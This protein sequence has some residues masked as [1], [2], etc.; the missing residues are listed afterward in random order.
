MNPDF[1]NQLCQ[2]HPRIFVQRHG[3]M[4]DTA[5]CWGFDCGD[6]WFTLLDVLCRE[7]QGQTDKHGAPQLEA[8]QVK[9]KFGALR[10]YVTTSN[11]VQQALVRMTE[12]LSMRTCEECGAPGQ[13][14]TNDGW[15]ATRCAA[16]TK[17]GSEPENI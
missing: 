9:E 14:S 2:K 8:V 17:P 15:Y 16:H 4:D 10:F 11:E 5:M 3:P 12:F 13:L 6:G 7:L 1:D